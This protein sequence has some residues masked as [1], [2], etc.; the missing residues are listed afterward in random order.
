MW[1]IVK[2]SF[3]GQILGEKLLLIVGRK[4]NLCEDTIEALRELIGQKNV[5]KTRPPLEQ[6]LNR[7]AAN[8]RQR[9][10]D[11]ETAIK[12]T[13]KLANECKQL[14]AELDVLKATYEQKK[15]QLEKANEKATLLAK[16]AGI[17]WSPEETESDNES[18]KEE[19][20]DNETAGD[21]EPSQD[22]ENTEG[23]T[24]S[25]GQES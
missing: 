2:K 8:A 4:Y 7:Q 25:A 18:A 14:N 1:V 19:R 24:V 20:T 15:Q 17:E 23:Q 3:S 21:N 11:A 5:E 16:K 12:K 9:R 13:V 10:L 22:A 6:R